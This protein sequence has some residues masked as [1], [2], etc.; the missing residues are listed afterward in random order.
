MNLPGHL[1]QQQGKRGDGTL[2]RARSDAECLGLG[3][4]IPP[5]AGSQLPAADT[6]MGDVL[7][8]PTWPPASLAWHMSP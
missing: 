3:S 5:G 7:L 8:H 2:P 4:C 6:E 1:R